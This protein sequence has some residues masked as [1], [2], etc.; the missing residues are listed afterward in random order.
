MAGW[1]AVGGY[2]LLAIPFLWMDGIISISSNRVYS[3]GNP[4]S[5]TGNAIPMDGWHY[6]H[7]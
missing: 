2:I 1:I 7:I 3:S 5:T 6:I 4:I